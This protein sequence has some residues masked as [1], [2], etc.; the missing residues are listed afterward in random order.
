MIQCYDT[1]IKYSSRNSDGERASEASV[2]INLVKHSYDD[3]IVKQCNTSASDKR[4]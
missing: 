2:N 1:G 3:S 4:E